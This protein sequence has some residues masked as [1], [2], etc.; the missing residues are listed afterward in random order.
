MF[1]IFRS[2]RLDS[3]N[4]VWFISVVVITLDFDYHQKFPV[5]PVRI[6][7]RPFAIFGLSSSGSA[8]LDADNGRKMRT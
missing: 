2:I 1:C 6:W 3:W 5:T 4:H 8:V 7:D